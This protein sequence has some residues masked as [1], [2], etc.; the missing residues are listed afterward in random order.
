MNR[1]KILIAFLAL[2]AVS[3]LPNIQTVQSTNSIITSI[4]RNKRKNSKT[5]E[6]GDVYEAEADYAINLPFNPKDGDTVYI[7]ITS[8]SLKKPAL[9]NYYEQ[10][11]VGFK[12]PVLL[13]T[14]GN[15]RLTYRSAT[16]NWHLA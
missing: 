8:E 9:I 2:T 6:A 14:L 15:I 13:N 4:S 7:V 12:E 16:N 11:I 3:F 1:R 5:L 10:K